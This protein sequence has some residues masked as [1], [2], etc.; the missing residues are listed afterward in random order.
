[1]TLDEFLLDDINPHAF[2]ERNFYFWV[3]NVID[4]LALLGPE[5][6][7][8]LESMS[9]LLLDYHAGG[10]VSL[11]SVKEIPG[12]IHQLRGDNCSQDN[13]PLGR[14]YRCLSSIAS[15]REEN[16]ADL[17][18]WQYGIVS[19]LGLINL[20]HDKDQALIALIRENAS[21]YGVDLHEAN[22]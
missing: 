10:N 21:K 11:K 20:Y 2:G 18:D 6:D 9:N 16:L 1:M 3:R 7:I 19:S 4:A 15:S 8:N 13:S 12:I 22:D 5:T 14:K 17:Y